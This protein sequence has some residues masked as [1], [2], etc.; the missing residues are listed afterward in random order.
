[1][2]IV[3]TGSLGHISKPLAQTLVQEQHSVTVISSNAGKQKDLEAIGAKAAIGSVENVDFLTSVF[4][5]AD[6]AYCMIPPN[7]KE[8]DQIAYYERTGSYYAN[9]IRQ[10]GV[11]RVVHLSSYGAHLAKG[12]G[13]ITGSYKTENLLNAISDI[14]LTHIRPGYFYYNL[15]SFIGMIKHAGFIGSVYGDNDKLPLVSPYDIADAIADEITTL[16]SS[17]KVRYVVSDEKTCSEVAQSLG[18]AIGIRNLQWKTLPEEQ[19]LKSLLSNGIPQG[20]AQSLVELGLA[21]HSGI[22]REDY[23]QHKPAAL[24][25]VKLTDFAKEFAAV[26]NQQ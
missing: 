15:F 21:I 16:H 9:A 14:A 11:K 2:N 1:M 3:L 23:E 5:N 8:P 26:Y 4:K 17:K 6:A 25:K 13:F 24:G 7:F 22:L 18:A 10:S 20:A 12:T 19:V